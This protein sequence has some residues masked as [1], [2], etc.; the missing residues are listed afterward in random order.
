MLSPCKSWVFTALT[1]SCVKEEISVM[2]LSA[3]TVTS[4]P[5]FGGLTMVKTMVRFELSSLSLV[6]VLR[7]SFEME[8]KAPG[9]K[10]RLNISPDELQLLKAQLKKNNSKRLA[11]AINITTSLGIWMLWWLNVFES[12]WQHL[13]YTC[14]HLS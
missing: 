5:N 6:V 9:L 1:I 14:V 13:L 7:T 3:C 10:T 12:L 8:D 4:F 2:D 11:L